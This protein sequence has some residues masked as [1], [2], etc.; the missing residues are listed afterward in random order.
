VAPHQIRRSND[1]ALRAAL[2]AGGY[3]RVE[4]YHLRDMRHEIEHRLWHIIA[5]Y[6]VV[7]LTGGISKGK[8]DFLPKVL[9]ELGVAKR[10][11]GVAQKPG[12]P[13]WFGLSPR[14]TPVFALPGNPASAYIC[15][16]R[17]VLP[18]LARMESRGWRAPRRVRLRAAVSRRGELTEFVPVVL[19]P[20]NGGESQASPSP[21]NTSGDFSGLLGTDGFIEVPAG[22]G[23]CA[24]GECVDYWPWV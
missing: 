8:F 3:P 17:Y 7:V 2:I 4:R 13:F 24:V 10:F 23:I 20:T 18:A 22:P 1:F 11:Q 12:K 15:L 19:I 5:E 21:L 16:H 14:R 6:D 9:D